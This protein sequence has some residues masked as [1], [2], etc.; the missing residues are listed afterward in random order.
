MSESERERGTSS[1]DLIVFP[2]H[3]MITAFHDLNSMKA[4]IGELKQNGFAPDDIRSFVGQEGIE[5]MDFDGSAHGSMAELLRYLQR[6]GPDRTY[7]ERYQKFM[8]DGDCL[9]MVRVLEERRKQL[10]ADLMRKHSPHRVTY[11][12]VL[13]IEEI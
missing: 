3:S 6:I 7:L 2:L 4:A 12:G 8:L 13:V 1:D 9:L 5:Q 10:A 11:F